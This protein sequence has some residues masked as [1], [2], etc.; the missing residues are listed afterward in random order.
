M[1]AALEKVANINRGI[2]GVEGNWC[3][4]PGWKTPKGHQN[5]H[6]KRKKELF[7]CS[8]NFK[9][10]SQVKRSSINVICLEVHNF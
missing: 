3:C 8:T 6:Y 2:A 9:L 5:E 4:H 1:L 10:L 7:L